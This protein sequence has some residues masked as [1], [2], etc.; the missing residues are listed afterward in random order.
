MGAAVDDGHE[1]ETSEGE[2]EEE[3]HEEEEHEEDEEEE[4]KLKV[5]PQFFSRLSL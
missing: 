2:E 1:L 3:E 4:P 5:C